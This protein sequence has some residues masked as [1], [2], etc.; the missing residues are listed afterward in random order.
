[1][2]RTW[3]VVSP[4]GAQW[5]VDFGA[6]GSPFRYATR[7]EA[8]QVACGAAKLHWEDR[9]EPAGA[10]LDTADGQRQVVATYGRMAH[11]APHRATG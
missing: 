5:Q 11:A 3:Y 6:F 10:R 8:L 2:H 9:G 7:E 1:M 4:A